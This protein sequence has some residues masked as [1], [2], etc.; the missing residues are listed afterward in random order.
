MKTIPT[1]SHLFDCRYSEDQTN[2][3]KRRIIGRLD[4]PDATHMVDR[5][6][7]RQRNKQSVSQSRRLEK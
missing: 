4:P 5:E 6:I 2:F 7:G 1:V 3:G